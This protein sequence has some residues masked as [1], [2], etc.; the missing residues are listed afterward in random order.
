LSNPDWY[1]EDFEKG[2]VLT[3]RGRTVTETDLVNFI[4]FGG[5]FEEIFMNAEFAKSQ[6]LFE[7]R[8]VP[9]MC[10]LVFAEGLYVQS[11]H[12]HHGR[13]FL[14]LDELRLSSPVR[15]G[16]TIR[17]RVEVIGTRLTKRP[18]HGILTLAHTVVNQRDE[19]V[20]TYNTTRMMACGPSE[21]TTD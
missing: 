16:D 7:G 2:Q 4:T 14:G 21:E 17:V 13:A 5:I 3:T 20:V 15:C 19:P 6:P 9:A 12:T 18:G 11:G 1:F 8:V 10:I